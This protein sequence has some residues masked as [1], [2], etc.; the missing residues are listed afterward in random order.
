MHSRD[1]DEGAMAAPDQA[2]EEE[3]EATE[4]EEAYFLCLVKLH[5]AVVVEEE[6]KAGEEGE[7]LG[8]T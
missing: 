6:V 1:F 2:Q 7:E 4:A 5:V 8:E 3:E